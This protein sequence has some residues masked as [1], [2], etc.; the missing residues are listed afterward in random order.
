[1]KLFR[2]A[3]RETYEFLEATVHSWLEDHA[4]RMAAALAFYTTFSI[5][6]ALLIAM[7]IAGFFI[8]NAKAESELFVHLQQLI[9]P[10]TAAYIY[11]LLE[12]FTSELKGRR[13]PII[14]VGAAVVTATAVFAELQASLNVIWR[15]SPP[16][17]R[18][19]IGIMYSRAISFLFVVGIGVLVLISVV[20]GAV[21]S[22]IDA[23]FSRA[24]PI[25]PKLLEW[26]HLGISHGMIPILLALTYR[27]VPDAEIEWKDVLLGAA[28]TSLLFFLGKW[29]FGLYLRVSVLESV[30]GAAGSL[31]VLLAWVYYSAQ[32]FFFGAELTKVYAQRYGSLAKVSTARSKTE[33]DAAENQS[34]S[35]SEPSK[36]SNS[37]SGQ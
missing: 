3:F 10:E 36:S 31:F 16:P 27:L 30:Y 29:I 35:C 26:S 6:P 18:R 5:V 23:F 19:L 12:G 34:E 24:I 9:T 1:M 28:V 7:S 2:V 20:T 21:L 4:L 25:P 11:S 14:G 8:G 37:S 13:L 17:G 32:V 15:V 22:T 33:G